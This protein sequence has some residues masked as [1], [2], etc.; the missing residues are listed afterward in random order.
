VYTPFR[1]ACE[2]RPIAQPHARVERLAAHGLPSPR[3][4]TLERLGFAE[5]AS[6]VWP[7]GES[8]A[9][10]RLQRFL[11]SA[12]REPGAGLAH[13]ASARDFPAASACSQLS[14]DLKFGTLGIRRVVHDVLAAAA[15]DAKLG[16]NAAKFVQEL[17]W[18]DF[19]AHVLWHFPHVEH[20]AFRSEFGRIQWRGT[21]AEFAAWCAGRTGYPI[22]DA[23]MRELL[24]TGFMHNRV[25]MIVASFLTKDL[26]IDWRRGERWFMTQLVDGDLANNNGGWQWAAGTGTDA[27]PYFRIFNPVAQGERFDPHGIYVRRWCPELMLVQDEFIH[28][29]WEAD[30]AVLADADVILGKD[31]PARIVDHA[32]RRVQALAM[33]GAVKR[34]SATTPAKRRPTARRGG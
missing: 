25:R 31:Y 34:V 16:E 24:A 29:P 19:Y 9:H 21:D 6:A 20:G 18:R 4:A 22:V 15:R 12:D 14:A 32:E 33:Y 2:A 11:A 5:P 28:H 26:L 1:N 23:G 17:R 8:H 3:L 30:P 10:E 13:Y 27:A 7:A